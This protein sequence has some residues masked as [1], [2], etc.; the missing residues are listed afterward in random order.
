VRPGELVRFVVRNDSLGY[1]HDF[2]A[3]ELDLTVDPLAPGEIRAV[4]V[5]IPAQEGHFAY[6]C[7]PHAAMMRGVINVSG[8]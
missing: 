4:I 7:R 2:W 6:V 1:T 3:P 5:R 8:S